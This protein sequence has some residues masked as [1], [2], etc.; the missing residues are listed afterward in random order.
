MNKDLLLIGV[1]GGATKVSGWNVNVEESE[2]AF[3][4]GNIHSEKSYREM[5]GYIS[6]FKPVDINTQLSQMQSNSISLTEEEKIQGKVYIEATAEVIKSIVKDSGINSVLIGIGMPGL[7]TKDQR[8]IA[9]M[10]NGPRIINYCN[11]LENL[12]YQAKINVITPIAKIGSDAYYCG[13]GEEYAREG[14]FKDVICSYYLG[15]GTGAADAI[16][17]D[18]KLLSLDDIK[19]WF[20]KT[21]EMKTEGGC[22]LEKYV[23]SRGIQLIFGEL[24]GMGLESLNKQKIYPT[25]IRER[26]LNGDKNAIKTFEKVTKYLALLLYERI[27]TL[28]A[29]WQDIFSF[30][31]PH[32][33]NPSNQHPF[34]G[35]VFNSIIVG[36]RLGDLLEESR[37]DDILWNPLFDKLSNLILNSSVLE[38]GVKGHYCPQRRFSENLL[39]ISKLREAPALGAGV[40][41]YLSR[42]N[43]T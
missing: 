37:G 24:A 7:K 18:G 13:L 3:V 1:D 17:I 27:T 10:A 23:S 40:D 22:S 14:Q 9:A 6:D 21:W 29:G 32:R 41:A 26:A 30:V 19:D 4:L 28:N 42:K 31:N 38:K 11:Y 25:K 20:V 34:I 16:K 39:K 33:Q 15:G 5:D 36:Q 8:G 43:A 12:L 2:E 35:R